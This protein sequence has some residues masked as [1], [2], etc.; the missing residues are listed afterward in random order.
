MDLG[1]FFAPY[2]VGLRRMVFPFPWRCTTTV[3]P[4]RPDR[5]PFLLLAFALTSPVFFSYNPSYLVP[6]LLRLPDTSN[7]VICAKKVTRC[8]SADSVCYEP[9]LNLAALYIYAYGHSHN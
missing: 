8:W 3:P 1:G 7:F 4:V 5:S 6:R 9:C 2:I